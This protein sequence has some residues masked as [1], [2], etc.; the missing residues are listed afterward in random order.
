MRRYWHAGVMLTALGLLLLVGVGVAG[1][2]GSDVE[3]GHASILARWGNADS[4]WS[5]TH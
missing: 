5:A 4:A 1:S 3:C 2:S